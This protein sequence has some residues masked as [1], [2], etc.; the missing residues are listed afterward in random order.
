VKNFV[1]LL[2][3]MS[4]AIFPTAAQ[5]K[6]QKQNESAMRMMVS[7]TCPLNLSGVEVTELDT[8]T[9]VEVNITT[10]TENVAELRRRVER[11]IAMHN[12]EHSTMPMMQRT[13]ISGTV[14]YEPIENGA[15]LTLTPTDPAKLSQF[16]TQVKAH[17]ESAK[18][19]EC[20]MI[21]NMMRG[22]MGDRHRPAPET[23]PETRKNDAD[24][25]AHH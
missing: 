18:K 12:N 3:L 4:A 2:I 25:S 13:V 5:D 7:E 1:T 24:H 10:Q 11:F 9:G 6:Q 19:G 8:P 15:R 22:M 21:E 17:I 16:R 14:N 20:P 23:N